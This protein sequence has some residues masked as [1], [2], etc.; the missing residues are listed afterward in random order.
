MSCGIRKIRTG[1]GCI[2]AHDRLVRLCIGSLVLIPLLSGCATMPAAL[3]PHGPAARQ[4][5]D[6]WWFMFW[7]ASAIFVGVMGLLLFA[8]FR[9]PTEF[10]DTR[11]SGRGI[12]M[13]VGGGIVLPVIVLGVLNVLNIGTLRALTA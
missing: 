9:R 10:R 4:I 12:G 13:I 11:R 1:G 8:L 2:Q 5:A 3:D 6:L 7:T